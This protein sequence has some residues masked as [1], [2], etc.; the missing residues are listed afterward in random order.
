VITKRIFEPIANFNGTTNEIILQGQVIGTDPLP[1]TTA[2]DIQAAL[3][4]RGVIT[5]LTG[6]NALPC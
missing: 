3:T 2:M 1:S 5:E 6:A 4:K